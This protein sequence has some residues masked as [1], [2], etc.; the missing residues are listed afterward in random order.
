[1]RSFGSVG[2]FDC[3]WCLASG[4]ELTRILADVAGHAAAEAETVVAV[5]GGDVVLDS[6][7]AASP[8]RIRHAD[9]VKTSRFFVYWSEK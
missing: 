9:R 7:E 3:D 8:E 5:V 1:V 6:D 4:D 2:C